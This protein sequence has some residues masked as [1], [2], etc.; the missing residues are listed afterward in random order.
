MKR[1]EGHV[2]FNYGGATGPSFRAVAVGGMY[3]KQFADAIEGPDKTPVVVLVLSAAEASERERTERELLAEIAAW[4]KWG[5]Y[6]ER[7][8]NKRGF[9]LMAVEVKP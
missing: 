3:V 5:E 9:S 1:F 8:A 2:H 6:A 4:K 7:E